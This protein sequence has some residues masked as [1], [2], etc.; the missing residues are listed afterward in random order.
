MSK[1]VE[2]EGSNTANDKDVRF[3]R[4]LAA[5]P[6]RGYFLV[7]TNPTARAR[8]FVCVCVCVC[9]YIYNYVCYINLKYEAGY[10]RLGL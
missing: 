4:L 3:L 10:S 7:Q 8:V 1:D 6:V 2:V 9:I 5:A